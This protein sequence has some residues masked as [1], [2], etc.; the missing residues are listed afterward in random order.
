ME[1]WRRQSEQS[2]RPTLDP[3]VQKGSHDGNS[4]RRVQEPWRTNSMRSKFQRKVVLRNYSTKKGPGTLDSFH[5]VLHF[6]AWWW[7][8]GHICGARDPNILRKAQ[9]AQ[10]AGSA[11]FNKQLVRAFGAPCYGARIRERTKWRVCSAEANASRSTGCNVYEVSCGRGIRC[12][13]VSCS[14]KVSICPWSSHPTAS[15]WS[16]FHFTSL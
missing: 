13:P 16:C 1:L 6:A 12:A 5:S 9:K 7:R 8:R 10:S 4:S 11:N 2:C 15:K 14:H 3:R